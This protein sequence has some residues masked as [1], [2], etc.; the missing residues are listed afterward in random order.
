MIFL[1][2]A[3]A[4]LIALLPLFSTIYYIYL[5]VFF[6]NMAGSVF[7]PVSS[8]YITQLL[9]V[10]RRRRFN[11]L[12]GLIG[13][14]AFLI[15]PAI[16]GLLFMTGTPSFAILLNAAALGVSGVVTMFMP[17][18]EQTSS[19]VADS[20]ITWTLIKQ[21]WNVVHGFYRRHKWVM[22]ICILFSSVTMVMA[23]AVDSL[24]AAFATLILGLSEGDYG[25]LVSIAGV[26]IVIGASVN[27]LIVNRVTTDWM[28][29][30]GIMGMCGG[31]IR[32]YRICDLLSKP[33]SS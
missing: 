25:I 31:Y 16:A 30:G 33:Y 21:D 24:E 19:G 22:V 29:V 7:G 12:N 14:G 4:M 3:R 23:S 32:Q 11:S 13:S 6:I 17:N 26:G 9:P 1:D 5:I 15:G 20:K 2:M 10:E 27:T 28:I 8:T 18:L